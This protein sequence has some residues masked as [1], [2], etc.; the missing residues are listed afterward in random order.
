MNNCVYLNQ[1]LLARIKALLCFYLQTSGS[2]FLSWAP[3][4]GA[5]ALLLYASPAPSS[6]CKQMKPMSVTEGAKRKDMKASTCKEKHQ[7][8]WFYMLSLNLLMLFLCITILC[9]TL[10]LCFITEKINKRKWNWNLHIL[11]NR[12]QL[13]YITRLRS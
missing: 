12:S 13:W 1:F 4:A 3:L 10:L 9:V 8:F 11:H 2:V 5:P 7:Q 6:A